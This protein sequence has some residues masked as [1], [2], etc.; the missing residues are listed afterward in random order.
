MAAPGTFVSNFTNGTITV[1]DGTGTP[2]TLTL[3]LD[4]GNFSVSGLADRLREIG[5]YETRGA[6]RGLSLTTRTYPSLSFSS[7]ISEWTDAST[8]TLMDMVLGT[9]GSAFAARVGTLGATHP[10]VTLDIE[11][12]FTDFA[13]TAHDLK[14]HDV[15]ISFDFSEGDPDTLSFSGTVYG[16]IDGDLSMDG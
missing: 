3:S 13:G 9:T 16:E 12:K 6:L 1:S 7:L 10:V 11:F 8:G 14:F 5:A 2:L 4:E 15:L